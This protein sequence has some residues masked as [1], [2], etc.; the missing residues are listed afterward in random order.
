MTLPSMN[1]TGRSFTPGTWPVRTYRTINGT[2][3]RRL[4]GSLPSDYRA[5]FEFF[6]TTTEVAQCNKEFEDAKGT[7][8]PVELPESFYAGNDDVK[9]P[10]GFEWRFAEPPSSRDVFPGR[11]RLTLTFTGDPE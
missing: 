4:T 1:P 8:L 2:L 5:S 3:Y 7:F 11:A 6:A 10:T 9:L